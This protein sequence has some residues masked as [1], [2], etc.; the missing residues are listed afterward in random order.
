[1]CS[2]VQISLFWAFFGTLRVIIWGKGHARSQIVACQASRSIEDK[3]HQFEITR[4]RDRIT[5]INI[6][7]FKTANIAVLGLFWAKNGVFWSWRP[8]FSGFN[9]MQH[10]C[11]G[12]QHPQ[13]T[14]GGGKIS[15]S[16]PEIPGF[17]TL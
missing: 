14:G 15:P 2:K 3:L 13:V 11:L 6:Y 16:S 9:G 17:S 7:V 5:L 4:K 1:M 10:I 8:L 12:V